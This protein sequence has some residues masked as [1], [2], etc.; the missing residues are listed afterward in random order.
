MESLSLSSDNLHQVVDALHAILGT[1]ENN[2]HHP[3]F[4][5]NESKYLNE[6]IDSTYV[7]S[8][9][10]FVDK[11]ERD[12]AIFTGAKY[13]I[14]V[15]N[16]TAALH[17]ALL[18]SGVRSGDEVLVPTL[19]FIGTPNAVSYCG[20][21]PHFVDSEDKTFGIDPIKLRNWLN[22]IS[23]IRDG[24]CI[25]RQTGNVIRALVPVHV[26]GHPCAIG[27]LVELATE[28]HLNLVEDAAEALGSWYRG[29]HAGTFGSLGVLSFNGNKIITTGGG[30][31]I[32][33]DNYELAM[34]A[35]HLSTTAKKAHLYY[36]DHDLIGFNYRMPNINAALGC[37]QLELVSEFIDSKR[38]LYEAYASAFRLI[39]GLKIFK[40]PNESKSNYWLQA[41]VLDPKNIHLREGLLKLTNASKIMTRPIWRLNH[42]QGPYK[43]SPRADDLT[44]AESLV[45]RVINIPSSAGYI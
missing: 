11:F 13:A 12:L 20:A 37:A 25:N 16:G 27:E 38:A 31:A 3:V 23:Y 36:F 43:M 32:L 14:S 30:G 33:T 39:S 17:L 7:S 1:G 2:L 21:T 44:M 18:L 34:R 29:R 28:F 8:V 26:F 10:P 42:N 5:G 35:K 15:V 22:K 4:R 41:L 19:T 45:E 9:G 24:V 6:C 40:E